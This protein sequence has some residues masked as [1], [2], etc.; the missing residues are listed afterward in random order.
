MEG[1]VRIDWGFGVEPLMETVTDEPHDGE[2]EATPVCPMCLQPCDPKAYYCPHCGSNSPINPL[3]SYM[4]FV[5]IRFNIGMIGKLW[6]RAV[7]APDTH[8]L[9]R[10]AL[11]ALLL[12]STPL[13]L[14]GLPWAMADRLGHHDY[15]KVLFMTP[16]LLLLLAQLWLLIDH[17]LGALLPL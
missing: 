10:V 9:K 8:L 7:E 1:A 16:L 17:I 4:P 12:Y 2:G 11:L 15:R 5:D 6:E 3:A 13:I 14:L